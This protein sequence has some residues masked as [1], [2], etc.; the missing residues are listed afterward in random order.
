MTYGTVIVGNGR[1]SKGQGEI[2]LPHRAKRRHV[3]H[4]ED[5]TSGSPLKIRKLCEVPSQNLSSASGTIVGVVGSGE[6]AESPKMLR[7][8]R[9]IEE[10]V[11]ACKALAKYAHMIDTTPI[12]YAGPAIMGH[13]GGYGS[14]KTRAHVGDGTEHD[15]IPSI[16][17]IGMAY[18]TKLGRAL[19]SA[20]YK[21]LHDRATAI[22]IPDY[23]HALS[24]TY[25]ARN[26]TTQ[27][28][29]DS[30]DLYAAACKDIEYLR[31]NL[32]DAEVADEQIQYFANL[33]HLRNSLLGIYSLPDQEQEALLIFADQ[34]AVKATSISSV[35]FT[36]DPSQAQESQEDR[37]GQAMPFPSLDEISTTQ[38]IALEAAYTMDVDVVPFCGVGETL[39]VNRLALFNDEQMMRV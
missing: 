32:Q 2:D 17:A 18:K 36:V 21:L 26:T 8:R 20:E 23:V 7:Y 39:I 38:S 14:L 33:I 6:V 37:L 12:K 15:H 19:T 24:R 29:N 27:I 1:S 13:V 16:A 10:K 35:S 4:E 11:V 31:V 25:K 5:E 28:A 34:I 30:L 9:R 22:E 3:A